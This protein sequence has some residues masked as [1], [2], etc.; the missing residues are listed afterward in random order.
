MN[1]NV[2]SGYQVQGG[3]VPP[4]VISTYRYIRLEILHQLSEG[5]SLIYR[6]SGLVRCKGS[7]ESIA[8][9][10]VRGYAGLEQADRAGPCVL[11]S[12]RNYNLQITFRN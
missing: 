12:L 11:V 6:R 7:T 3:S 5:T 9:A 4:V 1:A 10:V 2:Y 8:Q